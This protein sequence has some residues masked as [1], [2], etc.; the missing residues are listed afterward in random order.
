[1]F[2]IPPAYFES[3]YGKLPTVKKTHAEAVKMM[4]EEGAT[5][6]DAEFQVAIAESLGSQVKIGKQMV[7]VVKDETA[8]T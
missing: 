5:P 4:I 6:K 3:K 8:T 1:M 7:A 2:T